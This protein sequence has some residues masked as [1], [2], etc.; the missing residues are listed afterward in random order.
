MIRLRLKE[1][2][3]KKSFETGEPLRLDDVAAAT[4]IHRATLSSLSAPRPIHTTTDNLDRLCFFFGC[5]IEELVEYVPTP[6]P[7]PRTRT[8]KPTGATGED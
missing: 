5:K 7:A 6:P 2:L 8:K 4:G 1:L 3:A